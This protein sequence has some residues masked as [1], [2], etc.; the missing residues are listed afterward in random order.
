MASGVDGDD[1]T[2]AATGQR[3]TSVLDKATVELRGPMALLGFLLQRSFRANGE[4]VLDELRYRT[5]E[6]TP[7]PRKVAAMRREPVP[8]AAVLSTGAC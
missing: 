8:T 3:R 7:H 2:S 6:G 4:R 1:A 5:E